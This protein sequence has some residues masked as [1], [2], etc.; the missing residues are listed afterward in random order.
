MSVVTKPW[1]PVIY[2][3]MLLADAL[4]AMRKFRGVRQRHPDFCERQKNFEIALTKIRCLAQFMSHGKGQGELIHVNDAEIGGTADES[5][6]KT[7]FDVISKYVS[8]L[9]E[10]RFKKDSKYP[11]PK[12]N[13]A[14]VAGRQLLRQ[15]KSILD[16][17]KPK[18][19]GHAAHWY[20]VFEQ[21][22]ALL[23]GS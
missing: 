16:P 6:I 2:D 17:L 3:A 10:Q 9:H 14:N 4:L 12:A 19:R 22:Y 5:F 8:H 20:S 23:Y 7:H 21:R 15:I 18:F 11:R 13:D 1:Q